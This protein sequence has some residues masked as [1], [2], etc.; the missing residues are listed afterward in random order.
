M[1]AKSHQKQAL[2]A[3]ILA[4]GQGRR[5]KSDRPKVL[6]PLAG[7]P[8]L[9]H[10]YGTAEALEPE[11]IHVV[12][13]HGGELVRQSLIGP[14]LHWALQAEQ[15]GTGHAL[16]MAMPA[17]PDDHAVLVLYGDVPLLR[18]QTLRELL[19]LAG[20]RS[21]ALLTVEL[22]DPTDY[23]RVVRDARGAV[24]RIVEQKDATARELK[25]HECNTGILVAPARLLRGWLKKLG[26]SNAQGEYYLTDVIAMAV[27]ERVPVRPL[28]AAD[29][30]EVLGVNDR[31]QLATLEGVYRARRARELMLAGVTI[32]DPARID[33]RGAVECGRD[34]VLDVN[35]VL[36]GPV[37]L[38]DGV[39]IGPNVVLSQVTVGAGTVIKPN[40]VI[41]RSE[42][43]PRCEIGPFA[44]IRPE[45]QLAE[46]VHVG[47]FVELKQS[48]VGKGS[49]ANHLS[50][51]GNTTIGAGVNVGAGT[52]TCNYDGANK[53]PTEIGDRAF[54]GSGAML[55]APLKIGEG[56]TIGAGS[57]ITRD[58]PA[59]ELTLE[60]ARQTTLPGWQRPKKQ[61]R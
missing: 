39:H 58:A 12:Y 43:G 34:V 24:R 22:D 13:G 5:M 60:R 56:A 48:S 40:C 27:K 2:S 20:K 7:H 37:Q 18:A 53:W 59:G 17:I 28:V 46:A 42:I 8:L 16:Q 45:T 3:V 32:V 49:K 30:M 35:V 51:I 33:I 57:T 61:D 52:I 19:A 15:L 44:R 55:V 41:E 47:N 50:Y 31:L 9:A 11:L 21:L 36:D 6:Q 25:I 14:K 1:K 23:G 10:A 4:A 29:P 38:G 54:I 26:N